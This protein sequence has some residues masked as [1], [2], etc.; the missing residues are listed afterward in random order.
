M[1]DII[2]G[3]IL[4]KQFEEGFSRRADELGRGAQK[5]IALAQKYAYQKNNEFEVM[6]REHPKSCVLGAFA[7]G[8]ILG[9][10][11]SKGEDR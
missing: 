10:L 4:D 7:G 9:T 6:V 5:D 8:L 3:R 11:L 1:R 2:H